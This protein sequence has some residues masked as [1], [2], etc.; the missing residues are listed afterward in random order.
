MRSGA[1]PSAD[2]MAGKDV[3]TTWMS[4]IAMNIPRHMEAKPAQVIRE[5]GR[6]AAGDSGITAPAPG[7]RR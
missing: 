7:S 2:W 6:S 5:T 3:T 1:M 4:S